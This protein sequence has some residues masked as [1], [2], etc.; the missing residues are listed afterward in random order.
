MFFERWTAPEVA[1]IFAVFRFSQWPIVDS[2]KIWG[3]QEWKKVKHFRHENL[4]VIIY[5]HLLTNSNAHTLLGGFTI[6]L[7]LKYFRVSGPFSRVFHEWP[8]KNTCFRDHFQKLLL[9]SQC[10]HK[11][12]QRDT[13]HEFLPQPEKKESCD[14]PTQGWRSM[15]RCQ[16]WNSGE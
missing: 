5:L 15:S 4:R 6:S 3:S 1:H 11:S 9:E 16:L 14:K 8:K 2:R 10:I 7:H 13:V 12:R